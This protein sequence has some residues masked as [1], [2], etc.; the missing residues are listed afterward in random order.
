TLP[1]YLADALNVIARRAEVTLFM[2]S[3]AAF[4]TLIY[5]YTQQSDI[6][7]GIPVANRNR[8]ETGGVVGLFVNTLVMR[9]H[10][11]HDIT[12]RELLRRLRDAS[13]E[14]YSNQDLHFEQLLEA[15][16]LER[17]LSRTP[18]FQVMFTLENERRQSLEMPGLEV[19]P[20]E[21]DSGTAKFDLSLLMAETAQGLEGVL[22]YNTDLFEAGT[23]DRVLG[24]PGGV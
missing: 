22:E 13:L 16:Q 10:L 4:K 23:I 20:L 14:A 1:A 19:V 17:D 3:L 8:P 11:S 5:R 7:I 18:L 15:L 9:T 12:F 2:L 21:V 24:H 6:L